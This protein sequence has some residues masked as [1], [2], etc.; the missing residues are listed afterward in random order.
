MDYQPIVIRHPKEFLSY[1]NSILKIVPS[2]KF[3]I[4]QS[5]C[6][7]R[8]VTDNT[9]VKAFLTINSVKSKDPIEFCLFEVQKLAKAISL[10]CEYDEDAD[11]GIVI[12]FAANKVFYNKKGLSFKFTTVREDT[13]E[14][15]ITNPLKKELTVAYGITIDNKTIS[16]VTGLAGISSSEKPKIYLYPSAENIISAEVDDKTSQLTDSAGIPIAQDDKIIGKWAQPICLSLDT[17]RM[18]GAVE[19]DNIEVCMSERGVML[20]NT[21]TPSIKMKLVSTV[22]KG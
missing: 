13:I 2:C 5:G 18:F 6:T 4:N 8:C 15:F 22:L 10:I 14:R 20:I 12:K 1:I 19:S 3:I 9:T 17:F 21:E 7:V 16:K 11:K